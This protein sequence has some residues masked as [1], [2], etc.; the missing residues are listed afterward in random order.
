[1]DVHGGSFLSIVLVPRDPA[2][3]LY[4]GIPVRC[5]KVLCSSRLHIL[6]IVI[7]QKVSLLVLGVVMSSC[8]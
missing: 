1:M 5:N 3:L 8:K 7:W 4:I 2:V 6:R